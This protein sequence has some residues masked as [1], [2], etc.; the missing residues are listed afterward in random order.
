MIC[1]LTRYKKN[2]ILAP[3]PDNSWE[4]QAA[5]NGCPV[6]FDGHIYLLY[7]ALSKPQN[8]LGQQMPLSS[9]G[10][11]VSTDGIS[12]G[13]RKQFIIPEH[14]WEQY[15]CEDPRVTRLG[16]KYFIFYTALSTYPFRPEG[17]KIGLAITRDFKSI[18]EKHQV[19]TFNSKAMALFPGRVGGKLAAL[20][21]VNTDRPP[22]KIGLA[23]FDSVEQIWS[24][25]FWEGWYNYLDE[26]TLVLQRSTD[27]HIEVGA[28]PI[29]T[30]H[31]WLL[32]YSYIRN[33]FNPPAT[34]EIHAVLLDLKD[35]RKI[36]ARTE[37]PLLLPD[38]WYEKYGM[39]PNIVFPSGAVVIGESLY[40]YYGA[41]D[42]TCA[43]AIT[44]LND[45]LKSLRKTNTSGR[46]ERFTGN[47]ILQPRSE[48]PWE[49]KAVFNPAVIREGDKVHILYRAMS[50]DNTSVFGYASSTDGFRIDESLDEPVYL[51]RVDFEQKLVPGGNSGCEDPR[52]TRVGDTIYM[53]YTAYDGRHEP[54]I[55]LTSIP[56]AD[57]VARTWNW[58]KP[59]L[60]SRPGEM[61]KDA[62]VFPKKFGGKYAFLHRLNESI[63]LDF[64]EDLK[65]E[66]NRWLGGN[67]I[68]G[69]HQEPPGTL[70]I[71]IAAPP[72]ATESGWL[73]L[74]HVVSKKETLCYYLN[75]AILDRDSPG[76]VLARGKNPILEPLTTYE[77][78][79]Q[80]ANVVFPC[81]AVIIDGK[82][83]VYYGAAD[84]VIGLAT[85]ELR[86]LLRSLRLDSKADMCTS[87]PGVINK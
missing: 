2:P 38:Y 62:A 36:K 58:T 87:E 13:N 67:I 76:R 48:H 19:T 10:K 40:I 86:K 80:V 42:T 35:P 77:K 16:K 57:F 29:K 8:V 79:G 6:T 41:A 7:R 59:I 52:L 31:G 20:L 17:I 60:I 84:Q 54:R 65:F 39:V 12:F 5:F 82:L 44:D 46:M 15:G 70:K 32:L 83:F 3:N 25:E 1:E 34:F 49:A 4:A 30:R 43:L 47:P 27:D 33:Y 75:A 85:L 23:V 81:G 26:H 50:H 14:K 73:L 51:P 69:P 28:P 37:Y 53:C 18:E 56:L 78:E 21:A 55:A 64:V 11:A 24:P 45:L 74:Y 72:I 71:G 61:D 9:V 22:A 68:M 63:W 66:N